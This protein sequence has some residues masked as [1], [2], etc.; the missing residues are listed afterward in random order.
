[1]CSS[2]S[3]LSGAHYFGV[4]AYNRLGIASAMYVIGSKFIP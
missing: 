4:S 3:D 2:L 1:M